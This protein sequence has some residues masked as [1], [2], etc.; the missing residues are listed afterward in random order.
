MERQ[1]HIRFS[2]S[3]SGCPQRAGATRWQAVN[4]VMKAFKRHMVIT[5]LT[6]PVLA[7]FIAYSVFLSPTSEATGVRKPVRLTGDALSVDLDRRRACAKG[8]VVLEYED[9]TITCDLLEID[10]SSGEL[11]AS[12][13]VVFRDEEDVV[14]GSSLTY[15]LTS[16]QESCVRECNRSRRSHGRS[17]VCGG[18]EFGL[19]PVGYR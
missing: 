8:N 11:T 9:I 18:S 14:R 2:R 5:L 19:N 13:N 15:D 12:G 3:R 6:L 1:H 16:K 17:H 4:M 7:L 10:V